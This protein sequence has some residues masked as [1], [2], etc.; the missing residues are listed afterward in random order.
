MR[1]CGHMQCLKC[2]RETNENQV[3]C[4]QCLN[5]MEQ[6]PVKNT[7]AVH[8]PHRAA[9]PAP[10]KI[11][12]KKWSLSPEEQIVQLKTTIR[13]LGVTVV[14]LSLVLL[15]SVGFIVKMFADMAAYKKAGTN[16]A[17]ETTPSTSSVTS[18]PSVTKVP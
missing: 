18:A 15:L 9:E 4:S 3:F 5:A 16:Y 10:K 7:S 11:S 8:L 14:V 12:R 6:Y 17:V 2:G 1:G 13:R